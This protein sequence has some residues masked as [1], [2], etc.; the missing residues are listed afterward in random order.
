MI[1]CDQVGLRVINEG[2]GDGIFRLQ[3]TLSEIQLKYQEAHRL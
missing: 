3:N 2:D 1:L